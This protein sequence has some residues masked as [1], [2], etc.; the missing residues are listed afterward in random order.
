M[1]IRRMTC[2]AFLAIPLCSSALV[3]QSNSETCLSPQLA[4][5][6]ENGTPV[7]ATQAIAV[8]DSLVVGDVHLEVA[9]EH[10]WVGN[11]AL[12]LT[13][14]MGT[15][16][17]L[18]SNTGGDADDLRVIYA[19]TGVGYGSVPFSFGCYMQP[20]G[21]GNTAMLDFAGENSVG[22]WTLALSDNYPSN[23]D[24]LLES[25]CLRL[26]S[27]P[28]VIPDPI[29]DLLCDPTADGALL[30]WAP[31]S[32]DTVELSIDGA[33]PISI[34]GSSTSYLVGGLN[35]G[36][37]VE[38][39][40]VGVIVAGAP[41][42]PVTCLISAL[43]TLPEP[44]TGKVVLVIIDGLRYSDG[45]GDPTAQNVPQ[46]A[47]LATQGTLIASFLN[48][49]DTHTKRA[50][51]AIESGSWAEPIQF[52]DP[53][54]N[55]MSQHAARPTIHEYFRKQLNRPATDSQYIVGPFC[56]WR[57]SFDPSYG[58][59][60]WPT[61]VA[62]AGGTDDESWATCQQ[63]LA[64]DA[65]TLTTFYLSDVDSAGHSGDFGSYIAA[66][67]NADR[68]VGELW[69]WLQADPQ[70]MNQTTVVVTNDHGRHWFDF[71][72]HGD[73]CS[74]CQTIQLLAIGSGIKAGFVSTEQRTLI[75]IAPT[76][77]ALLGF[78]ASFA[79]GDV[80]T[81]IFTPFALAGFCF[82]DG[83]AAAC[84]CGNGGDGT[85]GCANSSGF[86]ARLDASGLG[87]V[88]NDSLVLSASGVSPSRPGL[89][90]EGQTLHNAGLGVVFGDGLR[91][92]G[93]PIRRLDIVFSDADGLAQSTSAISLSS[94]LQAGDSRAYQYWYR[95]GRGAPCGSS[96]NLT[97]G[98][99]LTW[100]P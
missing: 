90:F 47:S 35:P 56:P 36:N 65:P 11:I 45:L 85:V 20:A 14:P 52:F 77:G 38:L 51:P 66:V 78:Q 89:F 32:Y 72:G 54:C 37:G 4:F 39:S 53:A 7:M 79:D 62:T 83:S 84:P 50:I 64:T 59:D 15:T 2:L 70:Y 67:Q 99:L 86:G 23:A 73:D 22:T 55:A 87:S 46:M 28:A 5:G 1:S 80:M 82:G 97:N 9:I 88:S 91:C 69:A 27:G 81:E 95:D 40:I 30:S 34:P 96:F 26:F 94:N 76:I 13:S 49:V 8:T 33:P 25:I 19:D 75:D 92:A 57:G 44:R 17:M 41:A 21:D 98:L 61:W 43:G 93:A 58:P 16:V 42:C 18:Q 71:Q 31:G 63:V 100:L 12:E 74:G 6:G 3:A 60:Y 68:I 48:G 24:G 29:Q 10:D